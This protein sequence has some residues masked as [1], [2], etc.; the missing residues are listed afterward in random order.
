MTPPPSYRLGAL[1]TARLLVH[2]AA[3]D[4]LRNDGRQV[5]LT[6]EHFR[7]PGRLARSW[8]KAAGS[9]HPETGAERC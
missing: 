7:R 3:V 6:C 4:L 8:G 5:H 9:I 2:L 1:V